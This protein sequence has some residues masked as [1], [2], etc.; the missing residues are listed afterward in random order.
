MASSNLA[1]KQPALSNQ[2]K[3]TRKQQEKGLGQGCHKAVECYF[4]FCLQQTTYP[5]VGSMAEN[6]RLR[7]AKIAK[8]AESAKDCRLKKQT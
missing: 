5:R 1:K 4:F 8:I 3:T 7:A 2:L 6:V